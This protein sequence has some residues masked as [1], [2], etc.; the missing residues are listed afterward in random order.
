MG[1]YGQQFLRDQQWMSNYYARLVEKVIGRLSHVQTDHIMW[2]DGW[3]P[4]FPTVLQYLEASKRPM[5]HSCNLVGVPWAEGEY[6]EGSEWAKKYANFLFP[7]YQRIFVASAYVAHLI[8]DNG[9]ELTSRFTIAGR[10]FFDEVPPIEQMQK[11]YRIVFPHRLVPM[12]R[13]ERFI[14]FA[15]RWQAE[16]N[17]GLEFVVLT[18][19]PLLKDITF[20]AGVQCVFNEQRKDYLKQLE[21][22]SHVWSDST[23]EGFGNSIHEAYRFGCVPVLNNLPVY[24]ELYSPNCIFWE[25][26][27]I[28]RIIKTVN[29]K[30]VVFKGDNNCIETIGSYFD[31]LP[32]DQT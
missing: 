12:R 20:D 14:E 31:E 30:D 15:K 16:V 26:G 28:V 29:Y 5:A 23:F 3:N 11:K 6:M 10:P 18:S 22:A 1:P 25:W 7:N 21:Q 17:D 2:M 24:L 32:Y 27:D 13:I 4:A 9:F 8:T 19:D